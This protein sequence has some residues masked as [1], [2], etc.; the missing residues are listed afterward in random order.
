M[1]LYFYIVGK[2]IDNYKNI[3]KKLD[4]VHNSQIRIVER[5]DRYDKL[6]LVSQLDTIEDYFGKID[7]YL[8]KLE[9]INKTYIS[10]DEKI[11]TIEMMRGNIDI[12][13]RRI[14]DLEHK[15]NDTFYNFDSFEVKLN[16][17]K[18]CNFII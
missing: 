13:R 1:F 16:E 6:D 17:S 8:A 7:E 11:K 2:D 14:V 9:K 18:K 5:F 10:L 4:Q 15:S 12:L 3:N